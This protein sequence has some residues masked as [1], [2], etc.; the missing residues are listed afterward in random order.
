L[1][2]ISQ[3]GPSTAAQ[4]APAG[5]TG[6]RGLRLPPVVAGLDQ[7]VATA[8]AGGAANAARSTR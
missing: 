6:L 7:T 8:P 3:P 1:R 2:V 4:A 5:G